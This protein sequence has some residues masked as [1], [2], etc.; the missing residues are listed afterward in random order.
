MPKKRHMPEQIICKLRE[1]EVRMSQGA[2]AV[3]AILGIGISEQTYYRW[4]REFDTRSA[5]AY[6]LGQR[7]RVHREGD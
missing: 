6:P 2:S 7:A 5:R 3:E 4:R 1:V